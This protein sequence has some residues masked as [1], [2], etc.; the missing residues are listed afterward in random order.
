MPPGKYLNVVGDTLELTP[1]G[2]LIYPA[3]KVLAGSAS[4]ITRGVGN[5]MR[6]TGCSLSEAV[7]MA[8]TNPARLYG[9]S[10]RGE[11]RPGLRAD[12]ILFTLEDHSIEIIKTMVA[13]KFVYESG[14]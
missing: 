7:G 4:P 5:V 3:Q 2:A 6:V 12:L 13:G 10:D 1:G 9:L 11:I 8:S 14:K